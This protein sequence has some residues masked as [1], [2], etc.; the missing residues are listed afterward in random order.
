VIIFLNKICEELGRAEQFHHGSKLSK[1]E[2][3]Q[4]FVV[5][6]VQLEVVGRPL[7]T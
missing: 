6:E 5:R 7:D 1:S 2:V 4:I 3:D